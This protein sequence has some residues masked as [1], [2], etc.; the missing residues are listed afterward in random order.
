MARLAILPLVQILSLPVRV[1]KEVEGVNLLNSKP[2]GQ[3]LHQGS[4]KYLYTQEPQDL[5]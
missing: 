4:K 2:L 5:D 1:Q 3:Q